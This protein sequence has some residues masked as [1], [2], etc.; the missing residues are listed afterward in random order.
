MLNAMKESGK[1]GVSDLRIPG[2][3]EYYDAIAI[4][5]GLAL[6]NQKDPQDA[7]DSAAKEWDKITERRGREDQKRAYQG[8]FGK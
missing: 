4:E 1:N 5:F 3:F 6:T 7:L 2:M 8:I